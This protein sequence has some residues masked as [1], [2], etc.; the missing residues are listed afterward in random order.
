MKTAK[1][2]KKTKAET[3]KQQSPNKATDTETK[4]TKNGCGTAILI[5]II[6]FLFFSCRTTDNGS[7]SKESNIQSQKTEHEENSESEAEDTDEPQTDGY[8]WTIHDYATFAS[9]T[10]QISDEYITNYKAPWGLED[11]WSFAKFD[12]TGKVFVTTKYSF[13]N[14]NEKQSVIC[15]FSLGEDSNDDGIPD[16]F[17]PHFFSVGDSIY[18]N[19][20]S[21]ND[22]FQN[23]QSI[24]DSYKN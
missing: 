17:T 10:K 1:V 14:I 20:G 23:M 13:S 9:I 19:D 16:R 4:E 21:C 3:R 2:T 18:A 15:I 6:I 24:M 11:E 7:E 22:F 12:E 8:G 5:V